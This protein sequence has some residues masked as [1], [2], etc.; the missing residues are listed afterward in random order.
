[1]GSTFWFVQQTLIYF[2]ISTHALLQSK[3]RGFDP[4]PIITTMASDNLN[5]VLGTLPEDIEKA[6]T[7]NQ[8]D[9]IYADIMLEFLSSGLSIII[10][11]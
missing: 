7:S 11:S 5:K 10:G 9:V 4:R 6:G 3:S 2:G 1:V 8:F